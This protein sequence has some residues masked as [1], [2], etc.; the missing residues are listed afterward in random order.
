MLAGERKDVIPMPNLTCET[1]HV[2]DPPSKSRRKLWDGEETTYLQ[3]V[4]CTFAE[5]LG[6]EKGLFLQQNP[7]S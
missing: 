4:K 7:G 1:N 5:D 2:I 3:Q 6:K